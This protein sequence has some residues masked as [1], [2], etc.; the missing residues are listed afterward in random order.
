MEIA[1]NESLCPISTLIETGSVSL[2]IPLSAH[3]FLWDA[4]S[5]VP[6]TSDSEVLNQVQERKELDEPD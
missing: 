5:F 1:S 2:G 4:I 3:Q 6:S